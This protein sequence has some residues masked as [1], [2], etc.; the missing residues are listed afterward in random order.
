M[1]PYN[2]IKDLPGLRLSPPKSSATTKTETYFI[3]D[4]SFS[5]VNKNN[6]PI[7]PM[8]LMKFG[9]ILNRIVRNIL[10]ADPQFEPSYDCLWILLNSF[11]T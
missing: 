5:E 7:V 8:E 6:V 10:L 4:Y 1:L 11:K 2:A 3:Y 9:H